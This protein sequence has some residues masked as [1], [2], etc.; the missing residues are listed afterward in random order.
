MWLSNGKPR[1]GPIFEIHN[2]IKLLV[3]YAIRYIKRNKNLLRREALGKKLNNA[4]KDEFWKEI[5]A[6]NNCNTPIPVRFR[7]YSRTLE[8]TLLGYFYCLQ[9]QSIDKSK[10]LLA[11]THNEV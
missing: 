8:E 1:H 6:I 5:N 9:K 3:K 11:S 2:K 7:E 4:N 10:I